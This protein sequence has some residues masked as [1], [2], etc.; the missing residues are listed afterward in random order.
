MKYYNTTEQEERLFYPD[1][2]IK[3]SDGRFGI[4]DTKFGQT[5]RT[6]GR[7]KG[8]ANKLQE[9]GENFIGGIVRFANGIYEYYDSS[10]YDDTTPSNNEWKPL[11]NLI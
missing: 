10:D 4:F 1:W 8:L 11:N 3:L 2:I 7:A 6:E 9:L 5:L